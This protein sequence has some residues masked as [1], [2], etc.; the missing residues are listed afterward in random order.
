MGTVL[1]VVI[2]RSGMGP[3]HVLLG[4][5]LPSTHKQSSYAWQDGL[6]DQV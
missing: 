5:I 2:H 3:G 1:S 4:W 6:G